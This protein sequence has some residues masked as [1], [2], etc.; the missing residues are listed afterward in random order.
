MVLDGI[1]VES[2][3]SYVPLKNVA[4]I[5]IEDPKLYVSRLGIKTK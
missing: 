3:G 2:Y 5:S 1:S 4:S